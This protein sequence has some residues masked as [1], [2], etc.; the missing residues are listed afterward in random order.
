MYHRQDLWGE[1]H[2]Q[3]LARFLAWIDKL[4]LPTDRQVLEVGCGAGLATVALAK[5]GYFVEA[6]DAAAPM[7]ELARQNAAEAGVGSRVNANLGDVYHLAFSDEAFGL[8]L[9]IGVIPWLQSP[10]QAITELARVLKPGGYLLL[11]ADNRWRLALLL[12]PVTSPFLAWTRQTLKKILGIASQPAPMANVV[13]S[14]QHSLS[15]VDAFFAGAG[16]E[17]VRTETLGFGPFTFFYRKVLPEWLGV[18]VHRVLQR[19]VDMRCPVL[20]ST[21][22][23]FLVLARKRPQNARSGG[24][25]ENQA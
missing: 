16:L 17:R 10:A 9:S 12:D 1:I 25:Q 6:V 4:K 11:T 13:R 20:R 23:Q 19:F 5:R 18:A 7:I 2:Q 21:G 3:R 22:A 24:L 14:Y 8:V 15:E